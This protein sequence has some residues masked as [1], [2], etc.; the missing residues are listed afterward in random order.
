M[1]NSSLLPTAVEVQ[2]GILTPPKRLWRIPTTTASNICPGCNLKVERNPLDAANRKWH[3]ECFR[4]S[5]CREPFADQ[6]FAFQDDLVLHHPC[7]LECYAPRCAVCTNLVES[8]QGVQALNKYYHKTCFGCSLCGEKNLSKFEKLY[9]FPYCEKCF[10]ELK[11]TFPKCLACKKPILPSESSTSFFFRGKK[12]FVHEQQCFKCAYCAQ[13]ISE[14]TPKVYQ[15]RVVCTSCFVSA[16]KKICA[17][18]NEPIFEQGSKMENIYWHT[19]HFV[20]SICKTPLR[21]NTSNL[22]FGVLKCRICS[23]DE[24]PKCLGCGNPVQDAGIMFAGSTYHKKCMKCQF[25][26]SQL[27]SKSIPNVSNKPCCEEC[28]REM[29][30]QGKI[31][32]KG[33][34]IDGGDDQ[35]GASNNKK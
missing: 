2:I 19:D 8:S 20:C 26:S 9:N 30:E 27:T 24:R 23:N 1:T 4:C 12:Y 22:I 31:D 16:H 18:C 21:P 7:F 10:N 14:E 25:C 32:K 13:T 3:P 29:Q 34:L 11:E 17:Q 15:S 33:R 28:Y 5:L 35:Q 6:S